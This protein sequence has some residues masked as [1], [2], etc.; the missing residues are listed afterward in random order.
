MVTIKSEGIKTALND[1]IL[2]NYLVEKNYKVQP[3]IT[4]L[5]SALDCTSNLTS[6][7]T[8]LPA[9]K[10]ITAPSKIVWLDEIFYTLL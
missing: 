6:N 5:N 3:I 1:I 7:K 2:Y 9:S 10:V 4:T 8:L